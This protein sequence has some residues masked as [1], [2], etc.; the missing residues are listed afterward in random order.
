MV[1][2]LNN[3]CPY[4][5]PALTHLS[6]LSQDYSMTLLLRELKHLF[7]ISG[8]IAASGGFIENIKPVYLQGVSCTGLE[9]SLFNCTFA[10][11]E[12]SACTQRSDAG[13]I[14]QGT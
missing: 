13:V 9:V 4:P 8:A 1:S 6:T 2:S 10:T 12:N 5:E 11:T 3:A 14:C 7:C